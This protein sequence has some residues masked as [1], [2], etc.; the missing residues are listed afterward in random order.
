MLHI[1]HFVGL[2]IRRASN[3]LSFYSPSFEWLGNYN[4]GALEL[5]GLR[6]GSSLQQF[7]QESRMPGAVVTMSTT[8]TRYK[9]RTPTR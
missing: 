5:N 8:P 7:A 4:E 1:R 2:D 9:N 3:L 6:T